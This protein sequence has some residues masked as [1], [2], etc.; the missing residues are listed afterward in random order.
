MEG[1]GVEDLSYDSDGVPMRFGDCS[2][3]DSDCSSAEGKRE[4]ST[5]SMKKGTCKKKTQKHGNSANVDELKVSVQTLE[6]ALR[7]LGSPITYPELAHNHTPMIG[8]TRGNTASN[9]QVI[10]RHQLKELKKVE[11]HLQWLLSSATR[12]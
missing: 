3:H 9:R 8:H 2:E 7:A 5:T 12:P 4:G 6:A 1:A 11:D 10:K